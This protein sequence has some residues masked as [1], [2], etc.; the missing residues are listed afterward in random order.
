MIIDSDLTSESITLQR[1]LI[2]AIQGYVKVYSELNRVK[3]T[4]LWNKEDGGDVIRA[5]LIVATAL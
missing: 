2:R 3:E 4:Q 1:S 5:E